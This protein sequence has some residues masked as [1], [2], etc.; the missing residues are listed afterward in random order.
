VDGAVLS[1][2]VDRV[3]ADHFELAEHAP[4][5]TRRSA[6]VVGVRAVVFGAVVLVRTL[7]PPLV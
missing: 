5:A 3:G 2:T 4:E 1:G 7:L 6:A